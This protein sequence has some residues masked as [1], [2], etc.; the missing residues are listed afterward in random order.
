MWFVSSHG[1]ERLALHFRVLLA[2]EEMHKVD[3]LLGISTSAMCP[4]VIELGSVEG[5]RWSTFQT[6]GVFLVLP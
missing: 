6:L 5:M 2:S 4:F 1:P 3:A